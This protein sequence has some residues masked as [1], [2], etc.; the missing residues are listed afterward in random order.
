LLIKVKNRFLEL[1]KDSINR[2]IGLIIF[3]LLIINISLHKMENILQK[4]FVLLQSL[5]ET[6]SDFMNDIAELNHES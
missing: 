3:M 1:N 4:E 2:N 5:I 6:Q